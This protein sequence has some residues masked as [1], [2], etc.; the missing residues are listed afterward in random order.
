MVAIETKMTLLEIKTARHPS[1][2]EFLLG[3]LSVFPFAADI[4]AMSDADRADL[5][6]RMIT[7]LKC[8]VDDDGLSAPME[9]HVVT[10]CL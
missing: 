9:S 6:E 7:A 2:S 8:Y 4:A 5:F 10:A 1:L 3:Y